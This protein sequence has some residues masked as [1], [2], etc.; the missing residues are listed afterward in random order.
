MIDPLLKDMERRRPRNETKVRHNETGSVV[1]MRTR[2]PVSKSKTLREI[3]FTK[4]GIWE[5]FPG[6]K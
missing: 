5:L 4:A 3:A 2:D 1:E 6:K